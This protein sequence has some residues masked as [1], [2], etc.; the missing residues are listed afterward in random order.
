MPYNMDLAMEGRA[1]LLK[2]LDIITSPEFIVDILKSLMTAFTY[3]FLRDGAHF[4][5]VPRIFAF[6]LICLVYIHTGK[7]IRRQYLIA[8]NVSCRAFQ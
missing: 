7:W 8:T 5:L 2:V 6:A 3:E 1:R 4:S